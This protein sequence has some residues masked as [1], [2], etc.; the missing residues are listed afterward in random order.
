M[1]LVVAVHSTTLLLMSRNTAR[2]SNIDP[3]ATMAELADFFR[4]KGLLIS[5]GQAHISL[6]TGPD[7]LK[8]T[9]VS[10]RDEGS[11]KRALAL[12]PQERQF[13]RRCVRLD[14][15]FEGFTALSDGDKFDIIAIHDLNGHA[16]DT[17]QDHSSSFMWLRDSLPGSFPDAR[18][19]LYGYSADILSSTL[20]GRLSAL[21]DVFLENLRRERDFEMGSKPLIIM[22]HSLGGLVIKQALLSSNKRADARYSDIFTSIR[23]IMFFGTPHHKGGDTSTTILVCDVLQAFNIDGLVDAIREWDVKPLFLFNVTDEFLRVVN[24]LRI[25]IHTFVEEGRTK[26]GRWPIERNIQ[27]VKEESATLGA[28]HERKVLVQANHADLCKFKD[29]TCPAYVAVCQG[30]HDLTAEIPSIATKRD[31]TNRPILCPTPASAPVLLS[32]E[33]TPFIANDELHHTRGKI[34]ELSDPGESNPIEYLS[35]GTAY[36]TAL[37]SMSGLSSAD[38]DR[39]DVDTI[40]KTLTQYH[41]RMEFAARAANMYKRS[42]GQLALLC[43]SFANRIAQDS[44]RAPPHLPCLYVC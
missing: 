35:T 28:A 27:L 3:E 19:L 6:A 10:F 26:I 18:I 41:V 17:W 11:L 13:R 38:D 37:M 2:I 4:A 15:T 39:Q 22:A 16:F 34:E 25:S 21:S 8:M 31:V 42:L 20:T 40:L 9:T 12:P 14:D 24:E 29:P 23:G 33:S 36:L 44:S 43:T 7:G 1:S 5:P 30:I 32:L